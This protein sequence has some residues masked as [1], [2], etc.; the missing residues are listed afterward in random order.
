MAKYFLIQNTPNPKCAEM[1][2]LKKPLELV[3]VF[4]S[5]ASPDNEC[6]KDQLLFSF[7][8][9]V[10]VGFPRLLVSFAALLTSSSSSPERGVSWCSCSTWWGG[11]FPPF[12][13]VVSHLPGLPLG[14]AARPGEPAS[15]KAALPFSGRS[16]LSFLDG[17]RCGPG[18]EGWHLAQRQCRHLC[19]RHILLM[20]GMLPRTPFQ[21][22]F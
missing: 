2:G 15:F 1:A 22:N 9:L 10:S 3:S 8:F 19:V 12:V 13:C 7:C 21:D 4:I 5:S 17:F 11:A 14:T 6:S 20:E 16:W 18:E